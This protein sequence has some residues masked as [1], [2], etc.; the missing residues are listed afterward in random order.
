[1]FFGLDRGFA[2]FKL[3]HQFLIKTQLQNAGT[4]EFA[5]MQGK[6]R[7]LVVWVVYKA[8]ARYDY[9]QSNKAVT[10]HQTRMH[11]SGFRQLRQSFLERRNAWVE[12]KAKTSM[13]AS[14][15]PTTD[16][17]VCE[18]DR[19]D[20]SKGAPVHLAWKALM[21]LVLCKRREEKG[22]ASL[23]S[24]RG[25]VGLAQ[26][27]HCASL[28]VN[29][30]FFIASRF[31][32]SYRTRIS[33]QL[34][35]SN[36]LDGVRMMHKQE[37]ADRCYR[38]NALLNVMDAWINFSII[39]S[40]HFRSVRKA[41]KFRT[42]RQL[43]SALDFWNAHRHL[44]ER[45]K[46]I[47]SRFKPCFARGR[48]FIYRW[49]VYRATCMDQHYSLRFGGLHHRRFLLRRGFRVLR[50]KQLLAYHRNESVRLFRLT[51][52]FPMRMLHVVRVLRRKMHARKGIID[53]S[54]SLLRDMKQSRYVFNGWRNFTLGRLERKKVGL[55][56]ASHI[57]GLKVS[58]AITCWKFAVK[59][60][61]YTDSVVAKGQKKFR[62]KVVKPAF[63]LWRRLAPSFHRQAFAL[64]RAKRFRLISV[65]Q[66]FVVC[67][68]RYTPQSK[69][70]KRSERAAERHFDVYS[71]RMALRRVRYWAV[72]WMTY[73]ANKAAATH[74]QKMTLL[75]MAFY[76]YREAVFAEGTPFLLARDLQHSKISLECLQVLGKLASARRARLQA[77][78]QYKHRRLSRTFAWICRHWRLMSRRRYINEVSESYRNHKFT[79]GANTQ[80]QKM[81]KINKRQRKSM[82][83]SVNHWERVKQLH[84]LVELMRIVWQK[85][86]DERTGVATK[87]LIKMEREKYA[88]RH[89]N[90]TLYRYGLRGLIDMVDNRKELREKVYDV[91]QAIF[92][93][94]IHRSFVQF[95]NLCEDRA[96]DRAV[97]QYADHGK[98]VYLQKL[99]LRKFLKQVERHARV[100]HAAKWYHVQQ[101][102]HGLRMW[103]KNA[104]YVLPKF[105]GNRKS[106][107]KGPKVPRYPKDMHPSQGNKSPQ[108][109]SPYSIRRGEFP[110]H[111]PRL[112]CEGDYRQ[113]RQ[114]L[115]TLEAT[116]NKE[117]KGI[118]TSFRL[119]RKKSALASQLK[120]ILK[121][122]R[123]E[124]MSKHLTSWAERTKDKVLARRTSRSYYSV[125]QAFHSKMLFHSL[126]LH[127]CMKK[128]YRAVHTLRAQRIFSRWKTKTHNRELG[129]KY[130]HVMTEGKNFRIFHAYFFEWKV[131]T[132]VEEILADYQ[133]ESRV[134]KLRQSI[135]SLVY[136]RRFRGH[137]RNIYRRSIHYRH[138]RRHRRVIETILKFIGDKYKAKDRN[139]AA[140]QYYLDYTRRHVLSNLLFFRRNRIAQEHNVRKK[141]NK[142][143]RMLYMS[144]LASKYDR[145]LMHRANVMCR[146]RYFALWMAVVAR[147]KEERV[148]IMTASERQARR[149]FILK[150]F[151]VRALRKAIRKVF[152]LLLG[153]RRQRRA[154]EGV[155]SQRASYSQNRSLGHLLAM[156]RKRRKARKLGSCVDAVRQE[157]AQRR[158]LLLFETKVAGR[159]ATKQSGRLMDLHCRKAAMR[160]GLMALMPRVRGTE[161]GHGAI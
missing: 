28:K 118:N 40:D 69:H 26:F 152:R 16:A 1:V 84:Y 147:R 104:P 93:I 12:K 159:W 66:K 92:A 132:W 148:P 113:S 71:Q 143:A 120:A 131:N 19:E 142:F 102:K 74:M 149:Q 115:A 137:S 126:V 9:K 91:E 37:A 41:L 49:R 101:L 82:H 80:I 117:W 43:S 31:S 59:V 140:H 45:N 81:G 133:K 35:R 73:R 36:M 108:K 114:R 61:A 90:L 46:K 110:K 60:M 76:G 121:G 5:A 2:S 8:A 107:R 138:D 99:G 77:Q 57:N 39:S 156:R 97:M 158:A 7:M 154:I 53:D 134:A 47:L 94:Y 124:K 55:E 144:V 62:L 6:R 145:S 65:W 150:F 109:S 34:L 87:K 111:D 139:K 125:Y 89:R 116:R 23:E 52:L 33:L 4:D 15:A 83:R 29:R 128:S 32:M 10:F 42:K 127:R 86:E 64:K 18:L 151:A 70:A 155:H 95:A 129:R 48:S 123:E 105:H 3:H 98:M 75:S 13:K 130:L 51:R 63:K 136:A 30:N 25:A 141:F 135:D 11:K 78:H 112:S 96:D 68:R 56:A 27:R 157:T 122:Q 106:R 50:H 119:W 161:R 44:Q 160:R 79:V 22:I 24:R 103:K 21:G 67:A 38:Q 17:A 54:R 20:D 14:E 85:H 72:N 153:I 88:P 146:R 100:K 58:N